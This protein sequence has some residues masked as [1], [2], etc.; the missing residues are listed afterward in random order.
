[1]EVSDWPW[2]WDKEQSLAP[3]EAV[4]TGHS[5][6]TDAREPRLNLD[7]AKA[8]Q[9]G[10]LCIWNAEHA[11][12]ATSLSQSASAFCLLIAVSALLL[13]GNRLLSG[14]MSEVYY[15]SIQKR[16]EPIMEN[17]QVWVG[18]LEALLPWIGMA[19]GLALVAIT[20]SAEGREIDEILKRF[21][22]LPTVIPFQR[23]E[24]NVTATALAWTAVGVLLTGLAVNA[25]LI[26]ALPSNIFRRGVLLF[27]CLTFVVL[28]GAP[29]I[30]AQLPASHHFDLVHVSRSLG[31]MAI[32]FAVTIAF[33]VLVG[34]VAYY[35]TSVGFPCFFVWCY[36]RPSQYCWDGPSTP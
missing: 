26:R 28:I 8:G 19:G 5:S 35:S 24:I 4:A 2:L 25:L 22:N 27:A 15:D 12:Q 29:P 11:S 18:R 9:F 16:P 31:P 14:K 33:S 6:C 32:T 21:P 36:W 1:M 7:N 30:L 13:V 23:R 34:A 20:V 10:E 17:L 3:I